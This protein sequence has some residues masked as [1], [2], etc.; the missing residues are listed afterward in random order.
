VKQSNLVHFSLCVVNKAVLRTSSFLLNDNQTESWMDLPQATQ[1][2]T[3]TRLMSAV[4]DSA[5][6]LART[7]D[8]PKTIVNVTLNIGKFVFYT[9]RSDVIGGI[10]CVTK[11]ELNAEI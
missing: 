10:I 11:T 9:R 4:E 5:Y 8:Q 6:Q 3:A 1:S 2:K 7:C